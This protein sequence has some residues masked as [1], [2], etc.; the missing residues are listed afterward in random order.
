MRGFYIPI[1]LSIFFAFAVGHVAAKPTTSHEQVKINGSVKDEAGEIITGAT[2]FVKENSAIGT[3]ADEHGRYTL[4]VPI[5]ATLN[6]SFLGYQTL[7]R[8]VVK[9]ILHYDFILKE[10]SQKL[11][12]VIVI[13]Y[14]EVKKSDLTGSVSTIG[15]RNFGDQPVKSMSDILQGRSSGVEV[16][17]VSG[18]PGASAKVRIRGTTSI[19][20]SSDPLYVIDGIISSSGLDGLNPQDIQSMEVL[21]DASSTAVYGSRGAN[22]VILVTTKGGEQGRARVSFDAKVGISEVRKNYNL[23]NPYEYA[24]ALNDIRGAGTISDAD[25][26]AYR[27][28]EKGINWVDLLTRTAVTQN[29][30]LNIS[31]GAKRV[32]Y[33]ISGNM[34]DQEAVTINSKYMRYGIR[35]NIDADVRRWLSVSMK[36]NGSILH[37]KNGAPNWF[38]VLNFSPTMELRDPVTGEWNDSKMYCPY[39]YEDTTYNPILKN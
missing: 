21:K 19:N 28:G 9:G 3:V 13:G 37:Q 5:G 12:E 2:I 31:G 10:E 11:D 23:L 6:A 24:L 38:H 1:L 20:K 35:A 8:R 29:Y 33:L 39:P 7:E 26:E 16:T 36:L 27:R 25:V 17:T 14:G 18:M 34:L 30:N 15:A 4:T 22:G 32:R